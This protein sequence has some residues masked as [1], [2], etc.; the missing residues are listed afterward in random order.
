MTEEKLLLRLVCYLLNAQDASD[1]INHG[2]W[3]R[4]VIVQGARVLAVETY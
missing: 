1:V 2:V 3:A 4:W